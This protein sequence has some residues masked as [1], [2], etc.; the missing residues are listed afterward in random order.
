MAEDSPERSANVLQKCFDKEKRL[1]PGT[2]RREDARCALRIRSLRNM[3]KFL[4]ALSHG[5]NDHET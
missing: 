4:E 5:M 3:L 2:R 1:A